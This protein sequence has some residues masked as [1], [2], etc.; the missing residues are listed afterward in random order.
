MGKEGFKPHFERIY[1]FE[2]LL[3]DFLDFRSKNKNFDLFST[4]SNDKEKVIKND[5]EHQYI[6]TCVGIKKTDLNAEV[7]GDKLVINGKSNNVFG[8]T[9]FKKEIIL[10]PTYNRSNINISLEEG[11]LT[12]VIG[13]IEPTKVKIEIK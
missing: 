4:L 3:D 2:Y 13:L 12:I 5:Y 9:T 10:L 7:L 1:S 6:F 11:I 8:E